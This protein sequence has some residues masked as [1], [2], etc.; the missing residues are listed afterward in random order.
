MGGG[1]SSKS[2]SSSTTTYKKTTTTNPYVTSVTDNNGTTTTLNDGT[3][4]KSV[5]D[6]MNKN[7]DSLLEEYRNPTIESETNQALLKNYT[8]TL[9]DESR[10][11]LENSIIS[12][13]ASRNMLRSSSATNL[14]SD[15]SKN[16]TDNISNYTA[17]LLANSQKNTGDMIALLTNAY[18]QGQNA[19][20]GNQALSLTTS[21]GNSTTTG[22][23][24]TKSYSYGM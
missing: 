11:A 2:N 7:M 1:S 14:Y 16:I 10:K 12:P 13:L 19:V 23:G 9:N 18:L 17:E 4:Y 15:L 24:S 22:T 8:R 6:Y 21:S 20:N 5:Y 3:A